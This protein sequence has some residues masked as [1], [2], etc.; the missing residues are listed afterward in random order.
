MTGIRSGWTEERR[1]FLIVITADRCFRFF[2]KIT[3]FLSFRYQCLLIV[4]YSQI[5]RLHFDAFAQKSEKMEL[6]FNF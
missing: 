6:L 4:R 1:I 2:R 5:Q 3:L